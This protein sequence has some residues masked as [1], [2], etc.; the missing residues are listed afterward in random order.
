[1]IEVDPSLNIVI[2]IFVFALGACV[3]SFLNV[4][5]YRIPED[6]SV[7]TPRSHCPHCHKTIAG[8]DNIPI[9]SYFLLG[10]KCRHCKAPYSIRYAVVETLTALLFLG[11]WFVYGWTVET[12]IFWLVISGLILATFVDLDHMIIPDRV[13]IGGI[14]IG[15][16]L[17]A[18]FPSLHGQ[19]EIWPS[20]RASL[21]G[22]IAGSGSLW[23]VAIFGKM[24]F[25]KDAMGFGDV[26]LLGAIGAFTAWQGVLFTVM[27][28]SLLGSLIG[29]S[30]I[31]AGR[32]EWQSKLPYGPY[33][34]LAAVI[35]VLWGTEWWTAYIHWMS[36]TYA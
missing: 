26:K 35:W 5:I 31:F 25:K 27:I 17:S 36:G 18:A 32:Q 24:A 34:A 10:G 22:V 11:V 2:S 28:S 16:A 12:P 13:S 1:M 19:I 23:L 30:F 15:V 6:K 9:L 4:C 7:I 29:L 8:Y 3:G 21:I 14:L 20:V 33:L